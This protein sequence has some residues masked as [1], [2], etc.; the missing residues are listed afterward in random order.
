M[1]STSHYNYNLE[2][3]MS[4]GVELSLK[5]FKQ[6]RTQLTHKNLTT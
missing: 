4:L 1:T 2:H 6:L 5:I 3:K